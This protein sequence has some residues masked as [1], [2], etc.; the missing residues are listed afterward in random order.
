MDAFEKS[1]AIKSSLRKGFQDGTSKMSK[2]KCY[3][4]VTTLDS[5]LTIEPA[6]AEVVRWIFQ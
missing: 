6:Q 2:R 5:K 4:Y 1:L 3:G